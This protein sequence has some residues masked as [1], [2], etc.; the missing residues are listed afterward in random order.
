MGY[1]IVPDLTTGEYMCLEPCEHRDCEANRKDFI[2]N[3]N[4]KICGKPLK[5]GDK[6]FYEEQGKTDKVHFLCEIERNEK[7]RPRA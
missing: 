3:P 1:L 6:F 7:Q 5:A 2:E 4:C